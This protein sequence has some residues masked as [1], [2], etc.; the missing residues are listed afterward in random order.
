MSLDG[1]DLQDAA[2]TIAKQLRLG[3]GGYDSGELHRDSNEGTSV[4]GGLFAIAS[5]LDRIADA[6]DRFEDSA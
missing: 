4:A 1:G 3:L 5:A 6:V 2:E